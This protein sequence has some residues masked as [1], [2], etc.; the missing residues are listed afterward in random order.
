L[1]LLAHDGIGELAIHAFEPLSAPTTFD[2]IVFVFLRFVW[3]GATS[4]HG[5]ASRWLD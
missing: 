2:G 5:C 1:A 4:R 3:M